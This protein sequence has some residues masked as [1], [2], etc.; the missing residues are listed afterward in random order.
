MLPSADS[1][2]TSFALRG[3]RHDEHPSPHAAAECLRRTFIAPRFLFR[4]VYCLPPRFG[5][6]IFLPLLKNSFHLALEKNS[7]LPVLVRNN[8]LPLF[9]GEIVLCLLFREKTISACFFWKNVFSSFGKR[10][11]RECFAVSRWNLVRRLCLE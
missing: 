3:T 5:K 1:R 4:F 6:I 8:S 9:S 2:C 10:C 11:G 7:I